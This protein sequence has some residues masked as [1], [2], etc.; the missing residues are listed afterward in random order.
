VPRTL[1][2]QHRRFALT[3]PFRIARGVKSFA[4]VVTVTVSE[5]GV[6]GRGEGVPYPRYGESVESALAEIETARSAVEA[7][8]G[9]EALQSLLAPGAARNAIDCALWDLEARRSGR[10]VATLLGLAPTGPLASAL[11]L[12]IDTPEA[13]ARAAA[14]VAQAPL[15]KIKVDADDPAARIRAVRAAAPEAALIV[16]PNESWD[17]G[18]LEAMQPILSKPESTCWSSRCRR[19]R[20]RG[21][22]VSCPPFRSA[23]T[24]PS[25]WRRTSTRSP[26]ATRR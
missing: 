8:A 3:R 6:E 25:M 21:W 9:R 23:R 24:R 15:L 10:D 17:R 5:G 18:L 16:D 2:A 13:M 1:R 12:G 19:R 4:D 22:R 14:E 26:A 11:T 20:I 7:G